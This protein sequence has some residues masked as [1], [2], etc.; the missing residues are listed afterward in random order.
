MD[1]GFKR[2]ELE[3]IVEDVSIYRAH[4]VTWEG[5]YLQPYEA[6]KI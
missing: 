4:R 3:S 1:Q 5:A 6:L 2:M